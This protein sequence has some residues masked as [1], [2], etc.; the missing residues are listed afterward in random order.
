MHVCG[1]QFSTSPDAPPALRPQLR[2]AAQLHMSKAPKNKSRNEKKTSY[3]GFQRTHARGRDPFLKRP[4]ELD[5]QRA[6][7]L[8]QGGQPGDQGFSHSHAVSFTVVCLF[9]ATTLCFPA[10]GGSGASCHPFSPQ[11]T[12]SAR[13]PADRRR[14][15]TQHCTD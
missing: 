13:P 15:D 8:A 11:S 2:L 6:Y 12:S 14:D 3:S 7:D 5:H 1:V 9:L 10:V 4:G